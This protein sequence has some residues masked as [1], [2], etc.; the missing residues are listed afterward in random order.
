MDSETT[1]A[2]TSFADPTAAN[3]GLDVATLSVP[4]DLVMPVANLV[5][6]PPVFV[7]PDAT[8]RQAAQAMRDLHISSVLVQTDPPGILTDRDLRTRV[9]AAGLGP[10]TPVHAVMTA[11]IKTLAAAAPIHAALLAMLE[12]NIHHLPIVQEG[13]IIGVITD[14]DLLRHQ[15]KSPLY[16]LRYL[17]RLELNDNGDGLNRYAVQ[18][19]GLVDSLFQGGLD[20]SQIGRITAVLND[21]LIKR[22]LQQAEASLGAPPTP[23]AWI[24]FG[25]EGRMEQALLTDQDNALVYAEE[26]PESAAYF[27]ALASRVVAGL[28]QAGFPPCPGGYMATRWRKSLADWVASFRQWVATPEPQA[29]L[30]VSIFF[31]FR[32]VHG[33]L[34]LEPLA[35]IPLQAGRGGLF[36]GHLARA[37][38]QF[39]PPLGLFGRIQEEEDGVDLK[40]GG[41]APAVALARLFALE[42]QSHASQTLERLAAAGQGG[43]LQMEGAENLADAFRYLLHLRL[44]YQLQAW[45]SGRKLTNKVRLADLTPLERRRLKEAFKAIRNTQD[46]TALRFQT[47]RLA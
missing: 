6:R 23:Y 14:T 10:E 18:V 32:P 44:L 41:I 5:V 30:E 12:A 29:L 26:T 3:P 15:A 24:V 39:Q 36:L 40:K 22:L 20:V 9:V 45:R 1:P 37:A 4:G 2:S 46:M 21:A 27:A 25:S 42:V 33:A 7:Q 16:L 34:T 35:E 19:A 38:L 31:D 47:N 17:E 43:T 28:Q 13:Q 8:V 11:N